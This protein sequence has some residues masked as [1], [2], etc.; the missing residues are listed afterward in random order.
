[1]A[2]ESDSPE[3]SPEQIACHLRRPEGE[4][5]VKMGLHM[6]KGN[7]HIC[8]N[9]YQ[10]LNPR[11]GSK[12]LEIGMGNG[13]FVKELLKLAH[14]L[15]YTGIDYSRTMVDAAVEINKELI[16]KG[17]VSFEHASI[18]S[19][20]FEDETFDY[21]TTTNTIYFWPD[22]MKDLL[23]V[24]RVMKPEG[25]LVIAYRSRAFLDQVE[26][27]KYGFSKFNIEDVEQLLETSGFNQVKTSVI[28]EP[29]LVKLPEKELEVEGVFTQGIK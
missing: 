24:A 29:D 9:T 27:T 22:P 6:N 4:I 17:M 3:L 10:E 26:L 16:D 18:T 14:D 12:V 20:P 23:E 11:P 2:N 15:Q 1:M 7:R 19:I 13:Y 25:K 8:L 5:G 28:K 21:V